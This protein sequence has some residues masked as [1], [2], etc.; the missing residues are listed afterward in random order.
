MMEFTKQYPVI[1]YEDGR[2]TPSMDEVLAECS[3]NVHINGRCT[4]VLHCIPEYLEE[5]LLGRLYTSGVISS[6][7]DIM[8]L[9]IRPSLNRADLKIRE[10]DRTMVRLPDLHICPDH[11]LSDVY[12]R[13]QSGQFPR[14][15]TPGHLQQ[16]LRPSSVPQNMP[17]DHP[18]SDC[19]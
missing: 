16:P 1:R 13:Q 18:C 17:Q 15:Y 19:R 11:I 2:E 8:D 6:P 10:T 5:M 14:P 4:E 12:K 3:L 7:E 9:S